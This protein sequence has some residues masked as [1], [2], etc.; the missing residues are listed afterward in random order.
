LAPARVRER[1]KIHS[2]SGGRKKYR[3]ISGTFFPADDST[4]RR[5]KEMQPRD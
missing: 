3:L 4:A 1:I 5:L 2:L